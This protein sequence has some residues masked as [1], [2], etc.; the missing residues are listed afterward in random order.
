MIRQIRSLQGHHIVCGFGR[1]GHEVCAELRREGQP[2][3]VV[4][5]NENSIQR[6]RAQVHLVVVG[7]AGDDRVLQE[8]NIVRAV[9]LVS[10]VDSDAA[11][12]LVVLSARALKPD[13]YIVARANLDNA[14]EKLL[15]A[16]ADGSYL[17]T[18]WAVAA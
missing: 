17:P 18:A 5:S 3:V 9:G 4:D 2:L 1:V 16:G 7:D 15:R 8:A 14:K 12:L 10:A 6:A 13:L 11:N